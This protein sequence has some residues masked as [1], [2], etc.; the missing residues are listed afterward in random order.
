MP[1]LLIDVR[2]RAIL[3]KADISFKHALEEE[4]SKDQE[5]LMQKQGKNG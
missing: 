4:Q 5:H 3:R 1:H 2:E